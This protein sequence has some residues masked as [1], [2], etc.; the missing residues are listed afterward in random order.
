VQ[1]DGAVR[2]TRLFHG[3]QDFRLSNRHRTF[4]PSCPDRRGPS[5]PHVPSGNPGICTGGCPL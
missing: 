3:F 1:A 2:Q 5:F 4:D